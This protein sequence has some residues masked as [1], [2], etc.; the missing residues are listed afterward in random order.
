MRAVLSVVML[1]LVCGVPLVLAG[2]FIV[3]YMA[4]VNEDAARAAQAREREEVH[5]KLRAIR[6]RATEE[7]LWIALSSHWQA[8]D[9]DA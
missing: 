8:S 2:F 5:R 7:M 9:R 3:M 1:V 6:N 4:Q